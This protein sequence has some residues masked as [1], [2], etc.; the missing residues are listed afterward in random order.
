[1]VYL[2]KTKSDWFECK[3]LLNGL[4][5]EMLGA[6]TDIHPSCYSVALKK[7]HLKGGKE[8]VAAQLDR[9]ITQYSERND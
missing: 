9:M 4:T 6:R 7:Y 8:V 2:I 5:L 3:C 1:M